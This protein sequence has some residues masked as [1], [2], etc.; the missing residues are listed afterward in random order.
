M[1][2]G[3]S[4]PIQLLINQYNRLVDYRN[5]LNSQLANVRQTNRALT[6][7]DNIITNQYNTKM[8]EYER[9]IKLK[10]EQLYKKPVGLVP[11]HNRY[12]ED[13]KVNVF[14]STFGN[15]ILNALYERNTPLIANTAGNNMETQIYKTL[16][17]ESLSEQNHSVNE[18]YNHINDGLLAYSKKSEFQGNS[19]SILNI[20][21]NILFYT[22]Y[23]LVILY[24]YKMYIGLS[25]SSWYYKI[26]I[27][28]TIALFPFYINTIEKVVYYIWKYIY[29]LFTGTIFNS[30][31]ESKRA[32]IEKTTDLRVDGPTPLVPKI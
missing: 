8:K 32:V 16:L 10:Q 29:S 1:G 2:N 13:N 15:R 6:R 22:F 3:S 14:R 5:S 23:I 4:N 26:F 9:N 20:V 31:T 21:Y 11:K 18:E 30:I 7:D 25:G 24:I 17:F 27:I 19:I 12:V 28:L